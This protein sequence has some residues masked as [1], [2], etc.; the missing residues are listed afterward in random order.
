MRKKKTL[1]VPY[2]A[3]EQK[4][5]DAVRAASGRR[6]TTGELIAVIYGGAVPFH[7]RQSVVGAMRSLIRKV[8]VND[9]PFSVRQSPRQGPRSAEFWV[10][11]RS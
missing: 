6:V 5:L 2:S 8:T 9:E 1:R 7:A 4:A 3:A 10:E 11:A